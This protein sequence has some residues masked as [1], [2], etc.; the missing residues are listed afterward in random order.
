MKQ[1][2]KII[3]LVMFC[4]WMV[5]LVQATLAQD[6]K[7]RDEIAPTSNPNFEKGDYRSKEGVE[8]VFWSMEPTQVE[9]GKKY[10]LVLALHGRGGRTTA[11]TELGS[12]KFRDGFPCF[13]FAP[14]STRKGHWIRPSE[15]SEQGAKARGTAPM[16][17]LA[18]EALDEFIAAHP[19]DRDRIYVTGQSMGGAGTFGALALRPDFFA[20][21]IP[22]CGGWEIKDAEKFKSVPIWVFH[23]DQDKVVPV[24]D[25]REIVKAISAEGG[26]P[27][28]TEFPGVG[29]DSWSKAYS[30]PQSWDWLFR[31]K[32][33]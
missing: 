4:S 24:T 18:L 28:Y 21:A 8:I 6:S 22:V 33:K 16:L 1:V 32:K 9:R 11:A 10:P 27:K 19:V 26:T 29:H 20:G 5:F 7:Q 13:V 30:D 17:P 25:S 2:K 31:Q 3:R 14:V 12:D 23:G 15:L